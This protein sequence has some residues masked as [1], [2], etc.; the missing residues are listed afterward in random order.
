MRLEPVRRPILFSFSFTRLFHLFLLFIITLLFTPIK[1]VNAFLILIFAYVMEGFYFCQP[2]PFP[3]TSPHLP[4]NFTVLHVHVFTIPSNKFRCF[5]CI[6]QRQIF[7]NSGEEEFANIPITFLA[8][9]NV[10]INNL[11]LG[12]IWLSAQEWDGTCTFVFIFTM[13]VVTQTQLLFPSLPSLTLCVFHLQ[14]ITMTF[15]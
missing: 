12:E 3:F 9:W 5:E 6:C 7:D 2:V 10:K 11:N 13:M 4:P 15:R 14:M 8:R 1:T